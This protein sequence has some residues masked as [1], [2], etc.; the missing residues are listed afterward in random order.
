MVDEIKD[1]VEVSFDGGDWAFDEGCEEIN[2][3]SIYAC[4]FVLGCTEDCFADV[5]GEGEWLR[6]CGWDGAGVISRRDRLCVKFVDMGNVVVG[7]DS[8]NRLRGT[9]KGDSGV[10]FIIVSCKLDD[11]IL[12]NI[13]WASVLCEAVYTHIRVEEVGDV[14]GKGSINAIADCF[15][16]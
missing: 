14:T 16:D 9:G 7:A 13:S 11:V 6:W 2:Q 15:V 12:S 8:S 1:E 3:V 5:A 10:V 4:P